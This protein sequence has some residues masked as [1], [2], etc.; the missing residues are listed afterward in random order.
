MEFPYKKILIVGCGGAGKST[1]ARTMADK[2]SLPVVHLDKLWW[3]P[4]WKTRTKIGFDILLK[5]ELKKQCW[6]ID[7]NYRRTFSKRLKYADLCIFLDYPARLCIDGV[8]E[9]VSTY[10]GQ[11]RPDMTDGCIKRADPEFK[12]WI[13]DFEKNVRPQ[14]LG[15]LKS[16]NTEYKIFTSRELT[17]EW[18]NT[19][20]PFNKYQ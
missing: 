19:F 17:A 15:I 12:Q 5:K 11:T 3:L 16:G 1:L 14:M 18:L 6:I 10:I 13:I 2:F 20:A 8:N 7:G 9:R 4:D